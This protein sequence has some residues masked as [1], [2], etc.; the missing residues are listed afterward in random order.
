MFTSFFAVRLEHETSEN[1]LSCL[2]GFEAI[3]RTYAVVKDSLAHNQNRQVLH[4]WVKSAQNGRAETKAYSNIFSNHNR[5]RK[6][7]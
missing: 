7:G 1:S 2:C 3:V 6:M 5:Y 4:V